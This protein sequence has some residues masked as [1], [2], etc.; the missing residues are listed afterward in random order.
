MKNNVSCFKTMGSRFIPIFYDPDVRQMGIKA[1][2]EQELED[3]FFAPKTSFGPIFEVVRLKL[4]RG[5]FYRVVLEADQRRLN[6]NYNQC[7]N[8]TE[9]SDFSPP[10]LQPHSLEEQIS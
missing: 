9:N 1:I 4:F 7:F 10:P 6:F 8:N 5:W 2:F 3:F